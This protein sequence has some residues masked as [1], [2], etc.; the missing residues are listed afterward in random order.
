[1]FLILEKLLEHFKV[2]SFRLNCSKHIFI[3]QL[4]EFLSLHIDVKDYIIGETYKNN[5]DTS[6]FIISKQPQLYLEKATYYNAFISN[7]LTIYSIESTTMEYVAQ[8]S[9][10]MDISCRRSLHDNQEYFNFF[11]NLNTEWF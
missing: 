5:S 3:I 9:I 11:L 4:I 2:H 7:L 10:R 6:K 1:M 8:N